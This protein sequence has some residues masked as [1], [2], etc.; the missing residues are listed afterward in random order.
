MYRTSTL[1]KALDQ[2]MWPGEMQRLKAGSGV[3]PG[4]KKLS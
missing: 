4:L 3:Y 2:A 1:S